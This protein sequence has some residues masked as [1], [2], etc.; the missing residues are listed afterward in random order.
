MPLIVSNCCH[1]LQHR[2]HLR[3]YLC[4]V[5]VRV[6]A[7]TVPL[8]TLEQLKQQL[9]VSAALVTPPG[10]DAPPGVVAVPAK[11]KGESDEHY[12]TRLVE[13]IHTVPSHPFSLLSPLSLL[14]IL[15]SSFH[16]IFISS[17]NFHISFHIAH[18]CW[19]IHQIFIIFIVI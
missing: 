10:S 9:T 7:D 15:I 3:E 6:G 12:R 18:S 1:I 5:T 2:K 4:M 16:D 19:V 11:E 17:C 8:L 14:L 13:V